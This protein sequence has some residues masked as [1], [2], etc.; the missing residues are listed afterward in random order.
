MVEILFATARIVCSIADVLKVSGST[1]WARWFELWVWAHYR[2]AYFT[3]V[4]AQ[5]HWRI[6]LEAPCA[7]TTTLPNAIKLPRKM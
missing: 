2:K 1:P 6:T 3:E 5:P 7:F 4:G